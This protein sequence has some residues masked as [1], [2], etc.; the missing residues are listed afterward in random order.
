LLSSRLLPSRL[1]DC[2]HGWVTLPAIRT[3]P[4]IVRSRVDTINT[5]ARHDYHTSRVVSR[6]ASNAITDYHVNRLFSKNS[7]CSQSEIDE[8]F[9]NKPT[10]TL[11]NVGAILNSSVDM[12]KR[13]KT[14]VNVL[15]KIQLVHVTSELRKLREGLQRFT[16][17]ETA[18]LVYCLQ[19]TTN[20]DAQTSGM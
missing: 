2:C 13:R 15:K 4:Q 17:F 19:A 1:L 8:F 10:L 12:Q 11:E 9:R 18:A 5:V 6:P 14:P 7:T 20:D 16:A 3:F